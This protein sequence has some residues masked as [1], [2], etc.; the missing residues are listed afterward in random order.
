LQ[1]YLT[2]NGV[3]WNLLDEMVC[4]KIE[5][6]WREI[7]GQAFRGRPRLR[8]GA[9]ADYEYQRESCNHYLIV[10]FSARVAGLPVQVHHRSLGAYECRGPL[11]PMGA[12]CTV[13]FFICP[14]DFAWTMIHCHEDHGPGG[15]YF[16]RDEWLAAGR[17]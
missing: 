1:D 12:F 14:T 8:H 2:Q 11:I 3:E 15:P 9:K 6:D 10:P 16:I 4:V 13:E 7:Y 5:E 17:G